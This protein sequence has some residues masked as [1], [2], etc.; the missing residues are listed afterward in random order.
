MKAAAS[1]KSRLISLIGL[2][3]KPYG[4]KLAILYSHN[5]KSN[6]LIYIKITYAYVCIHL[7]INS[8]E[9]TAAY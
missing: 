1:Y 6:V 3:Q 8:F 5:I 2:S 4:E 9:D 7:P